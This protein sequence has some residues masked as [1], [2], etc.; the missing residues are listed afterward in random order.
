MRLRYL[1]GT[2]RRD[3][4]TAALRAR[5]R[6][7]IRPPSAK[8]VPRPRRARRGEPRLELTHMLTA[9][10]LNPRYVGLWPLAARAWTEITQLEPILV[11]VAHRDAVSAE[12][13]AD[14]RVRIF[15]PEPSLSTVFQAQ[16][17]R[18]L[19]PALLEVDGAVIVSDVDMVPMSPRYFHRPPSWI[20]RGHFLAYRDDLLPLGEIPICYNAALP[21]TWASIFDVRDFEDVR[22]R[23]R[24]WAEGV[25]YD[26]AHGGAGW[27]TDQRLLYR[28][29]LERGRQA[30]DVWILDDY[31]TGYRRLERA[32]VEKWRSM[33]EDARRGI[34]QNAFSDFHLLRADSRDAA[35]NA[36]IV[37]AAV[38]AQ[39]RR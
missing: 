21:A 5:A 10:D 17:I 3:A 27:T 34:E 38:A 30:R 14:P 31:F 37:E 23:L 24:T 1:L 12:L 15:E 32:Y 16:C 7:R 19:Y 2:A 13:A 20:C 36:V 4:T 22:A 25:E 39:K 11:L 26:G 33:S 35:V 6:V 8:V 9:V 29:L 18:L 28:M